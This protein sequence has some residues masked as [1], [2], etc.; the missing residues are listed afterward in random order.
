MVKVVSF[1]SLRIGVLVVW[2][3][4]FRRVW[5]AVSSFAICVVVFEVVDISAQYRDGREDQYSHYREVNCT[6]D[7][8]GGGQA[9]AFLAGS[10]DLVQ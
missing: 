6:N 2:V 1:V 5:V 4:I 10:V 7:N 8:A 9:F 3:G